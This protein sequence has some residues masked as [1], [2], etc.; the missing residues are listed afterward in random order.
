M[1]RGLLSRLGLLCG[2]V[3]IDRFGIQSLAGFGQIPGELFCGGLKLLLRGLLRLRPRRSRLRHLPELLAKL[4]L[5][6]G[7]L[8]GLFSELS[9]HRASVLGELLGGLLSRIGCLTGG[10]LGLLQLAGG[11]LLRGLGGLAG[12]LSRL[13][14]RRGFHTGLAGRFK[15]ELSRLTGEVLLHRLSLLRRVLWLSVLWL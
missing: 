13:F 6:L 14:R 10:V 7:E 5:L 15:S 4:L 11:R 8:L 2:L 1:P 3:Q 9:R 12:K